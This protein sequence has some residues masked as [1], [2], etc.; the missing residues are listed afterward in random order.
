[1]AAKLR[2]YAA[3]ATPASLGVIVVFAVAGATALG[4]GRALASH[5]SC[6]DTITADTTLDSDLAD[7]P[8]NGSAP[9]TSPSI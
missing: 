5:V 2:L 8:N 4:G 3:L 9:T 7:C 6:G 1:M